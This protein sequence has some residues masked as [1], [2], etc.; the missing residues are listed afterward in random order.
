M[1]ADGA[2]DNGKEETRSGPPEIDDATA[3][4]GTGAGITTSVATGSISGLVDVGADEPADFLI[5]ALALDGLPALTSKGETVKY[6]V[7]G[8]T[9]T[10][11]VD[12]AGG[13]ADAFD[14][15]TDRKVF[16]FAL[17]GTNNS[18][19]TFTLFDQLDHDAPAILGTVNTAGPV[20][21]GA[22]SLFLNGVQIDLENGWSITQVA[23][24]IEA[25][26][27]VSA[28][29]AGGFRTLTGLAD[30]LA[31]AMGFSSFL[32]P[33]QVGMLH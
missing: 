18:D 24:A 29:V 27:A 30:L 12:V 20:I 16:T 4:T 25:Q 17:T 8:D 19:Y 31:P 28:T 23:A 9:L 1:A 3:A 5:D 13:T 11:Y 2:H 32:S 26:G 15:L 22:G 6:E 7:N 33:S 21:I 10:A 14:T